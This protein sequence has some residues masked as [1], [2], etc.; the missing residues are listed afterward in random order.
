MHHKRSEVKPEIMR[1]PLIVG[2]N[3][4]GVRALNPIEDQ[5]HEALL[6]ANKNYACSFSGGTLLKS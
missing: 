5:L 4:V 6:R 1:C 2:N 3:L